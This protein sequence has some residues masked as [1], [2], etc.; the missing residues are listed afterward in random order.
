MSSHESHVLEE[1]IALCTLVSVYTMDDAIHPGDFYPGMFDCEGERDIIL[2]NVLVIT[3]SVPQKQFIQE[4]EY[5]YLVDSYMST[6]SNAEYDE[7]ETKYKNSPSYDHGF[8]SKDVYNFVGKQLYS[9]VIGLAVENDEVRTTCTG[10][11][12]LNIAMVHYTIDLNPDE[13]YC[14]IEDIHD[15]CHTFDTHDWPLHRM[16]EHAVGRECLY[17]VKDDSLV[18]PG[19]R[20][21]LNGRETSSSIQYYLSNHYIPDYASQRAYGRV[22]INSKKI[23]AQ[24]SED[25]GLTKSKIELL[26]FFDKYIGLQKFMGTKILKFVG[27]AT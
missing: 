9:E 15:T 19:Y 20:L 12:I 2:E 5:V 24:Q 1:V 13:D 3:V 22:I 11:V 8:V 26:A 7:W 23:L 17:S 14:S 6:L 25:S 10:D 18:L 4:K 16:I 27:T 21:S